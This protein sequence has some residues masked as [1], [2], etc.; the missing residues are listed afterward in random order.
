VAA[1]GTS[2]T[3]ASLSCTVPASLQAKVT[4]LVG[5]R[6]EIHCSLSGS[7]NTLVKIEKK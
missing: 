1:S 3:V 7:V 5:M 6:A 2:V 4:G